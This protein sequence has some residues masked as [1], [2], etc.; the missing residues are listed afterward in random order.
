MGLRKFQ[1]VSRSF[2]V[3]PEVLRSVLGSIR[4]LRGVKAYSGSFRGSK[5]ALESSR[6]SQIVTKAF[7]GLVGCPKL[8]GVNFRESQED[9]EVFQGC[10][11]GS[12]GVPF[13]RRI[14][15]V[16]MGRFRGS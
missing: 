8:F 13:Q 1:V 4:G 11:I 15:K 10:L 7:K 14:S 6:D 2:R 9:K 5:V 16:L 3:I 12:Q